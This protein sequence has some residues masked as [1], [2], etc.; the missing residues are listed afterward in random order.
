MD[1]KLD[2]HSRPKSPKTDRFDLEKIYS[3]PRLRTS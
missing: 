1:K 2:E 3:F